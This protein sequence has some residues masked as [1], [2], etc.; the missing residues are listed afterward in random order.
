[1]GIIS[2][3]L[4]KL[5]KGVLL[6]GIMSMTGMVAATALGLRVLKSAVR[7][8]GMDPFVLLGAAALGAVGFALQGLS[9]VFKAMAVLM[10]AFAASIL[11][12]L[13]ATILASKVFGVG[14]FE[15]IMIILGLIGSF[16]LGF[17]MLG[18]LSIPIMW[19]A[20]AATFMG[21]GLTSLSVG[22]LSF[23]GV[24]KLM[25]MMGGTVESLHGL[26]SVVGLLALIYAGLGILSGFVILGSM[27]A[28]GMGGSL[29]LLSV[30]L[31]AF[32]AVTALL[33]AMMPNGI[34]ATMGQVA[35]SL[36]ILAIIYAGMGI[37]SIPIMMGAWASIAI[38]GSLILL[39]LSVYTINKLLKDI[40]LP[41][42]KQNISD[43]VSGVLLGTAEGIQR[44]L[45]GDGDFGQ[46]TKVGRFFAK[47]GAVAKNALTLF[48]GIGLVMDVAQAISMLGRAV[49]A[50]SQAGTIKVITGYK[51]NGDPIFG[52]AVAINNI[53]TTIAQTIGEFFQ[54]L[55]KALKPN[56]EGGGLPSIEDIYAME[57]ILIGRSAGKAWMWGGKPSK[58]ILTVL[59]KFGETLSMWGKF[60]PA[61]E[62]PYEFDNEGKPTK[63]VKM[64]DIATNITKALKEFFKAFGELTL[65][66]EPSVTETSEIINNV[67]MGQTGSWRTFSG[68]I[69]G[70][71]PPLIA[72]AE[73]LQL[74]ASGTYMS[75]D[76]SGKTTKIPID[77]VATATTITTS[78]KTFIDTLKT[79]FTS[80]DKTTSQNIE[81]WSAI[82][83]GDNKKPGLFKVFNKF[84]E[85]IFKFANNYI[86]DPNTQ[87]SENPK[88][89]QVDYVKAAKDMVGMISTFITT[90]ST[91][92]TKI[93]T[94]S[95]GKLTMVDVMDKVNSQIERLIKQRDGLDKVSKTLG[96][97]ADKIK[98][99]SKSINDIDSVKLESLSKLESSLKIE[100]DKE[101]GG[102]YPANLKI[103]AV[104]TAFG[105]GTTEEEE[106]TSTKTTKNVATSEF[107]R[108]IYTAPVQTAPPVVQQPQMPTEVKLS[109]QDLQAIGMAVAEGLKNAI[110]QFNF[111]SESSELLKGTLEID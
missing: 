74:F 51:E 85:L 1:M 106:K 103:E 52:E 97:F 110:L 71:L 21:I 109:Q 90:A 31:L 92:F 102:W 33:D 20:V 82:L 84:H 45:L 89:I 63:W 86:I 43:L 29:I 94:L 32:G 37:L 36:G 34:F 7:S 107:E 108:E 55:N 81:D 61:G 49:T 59:M 88:Y 62:M 77:Y 4:P 10:I 15:S 68:K 11:I 96:I 41:E 69:P 27:A 13:G 98:E 22:L 100:I 2:I 67:L 38:S 104:K 70:V 12:F 8:F 35:K 93:Q 26:V 64:E 99:L 19:G 76:S 5:A 47:V 53:A 57:E 91:E 17:A 6:F 25:D 18:V 80:L 95:N 39:A 48:A 101:E 66:I 87:N 24:S 14:P 23:I 40:E 83:L 50:F 30:G 60:G 16:A 111:N 42:I 65:K 58:G 73:L 75:V 105:L 56:N 72:F 46:E 54:S 78:I 3:A 44:G 79:G 28:I 9:S